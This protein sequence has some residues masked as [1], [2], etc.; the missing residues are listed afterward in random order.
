MTLV[1]DLKSMIWSEK[2]N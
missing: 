2:L 1:K